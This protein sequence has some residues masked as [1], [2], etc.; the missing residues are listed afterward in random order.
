MLPGFVAVNCQS[1]VNARKSSIQYESFLPVN[2][3]IGE[4]NRNPPQPV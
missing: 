3:Q 4:I 1:K 2:N